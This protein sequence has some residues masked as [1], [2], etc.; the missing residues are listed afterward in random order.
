MTDVYEICPPGTLY[1]CEACGKTSP[2]QA[3]THHSSPGWDESCMLHSILCREDSIVRNASG[4]IVK[5]DAVKP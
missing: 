2:T 3:P 1:V 5:A 4:R